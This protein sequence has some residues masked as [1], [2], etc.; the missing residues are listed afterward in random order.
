ML[1]HECETMNRQAHRH[2]GPGLHLHC[3]DGSAGAGQVLD[4]SNPAV[5]G[6][7]QLIGGTAGCNGTWARRRQLRHTP[8]RHFVARGFLSWEP[9]EKPNLIF[10]YTHV[11][12]N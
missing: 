1:V 2:A 3:G 6:V 8:A 12:G 9:P 4:V 10:D 5:V 11:R 7:R